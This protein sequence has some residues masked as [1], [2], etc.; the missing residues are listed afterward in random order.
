MSKERRDLYL[1]MTASNHPSDMFP[2]VLLSV[3]VIDKDGVAVVP[4]EYLGPSSDLADVTG[5]PDR[6]Y[7]CM[8]MRAYFPVGSSKNW[9]S[10]WPYYDLNHI[11]VFKT[12]DAEMFERCSKTL[13]RIKKEMAEA[14]LSSPG[15]AFDIEAEHFAEAVGAKGFI[16]LGTGNSHQIFSKPAGFAKLRGEMAAIQKSRSK[17]S[18]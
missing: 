10:Q 8:R 6:H 1:R 2:E 9:I 15:A 17:K 14:C 18:A 11:S 12:G 7:N 5:A 4:D 16:V 13:K 3:W